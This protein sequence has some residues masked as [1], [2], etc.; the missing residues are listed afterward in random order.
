[1]SFDR[2]IFDKAWCEFMSHLRYAKGHSPATCYAYQAIA[3]RTPHPTVAVRGP[4]QN[5]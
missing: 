3:P 5:G 1:M 4:A 2:E